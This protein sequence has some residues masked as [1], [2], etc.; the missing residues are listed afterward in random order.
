MAGPSF[1]HR[2]KIAVRFAINVFLGASIAWYTVR[3]LGSSN[4]IWAVASM[5]ASADPH[6][7][8]AAN[9]FKSRIVNVLVGCAVGLVVVSLGSSSEWQ[10]PIAMAATVLV[11]SYLVRI[12]TMWRQAPITAAL[13][14]A[15]GLTNH[16]KMSGME[17][18]LRKVAEVLFGCVVGLLVSWLMARLWPLAETAQAD[19]DA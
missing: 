9:M 10:M 3:Q 5:I 6:V 2:G 4:P 14:I 19:E 7:G 8:V 15:S 17:F 12:Q 16:S 13:V 11:S 18:G 1:P